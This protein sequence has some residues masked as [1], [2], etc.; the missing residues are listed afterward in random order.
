MIK[1]DYYW[2]KEC[3]ICDVQGRLIIKKN[4]NFNKLFFC[5]D[6]CMSCWQN[7]NDLNQQ[8]NKF[9]EYSIESKIVNDSEEDIINMHWEKY[10][11]HK[12]SDAVVSF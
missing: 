9:M 6:E 10:K 11:L 8:R 3:P 2:F 7:E 4:I 12:I 5:C 1:S